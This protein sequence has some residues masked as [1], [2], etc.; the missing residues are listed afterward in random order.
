MYKKILSAG[1]IVALTLGSP[2]SGF[3]A[4]PTS[5]TPTTIDQRAINA[6]LALI[7]DYIHSS[8]VTFV[9]CFTPS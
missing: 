8:T 9:N 7:K 6:K 4:S 3:A 5:T 1:M 2:L